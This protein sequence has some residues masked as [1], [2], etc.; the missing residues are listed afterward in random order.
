MCDAKFIVITAAKDE[1]KYIGKTIES[2]ISQTVRPRQWIVVDDGSRDETAGIALRSRGG[3]PW[4]KVIS[5][6][7]KGYRDVGAGQAEA[8]HHG[9]QQLGA[10]NYGFLFNIDADIVLQPDYFRVILSKFAKNHRLGIAGG[11]LYESCNGKLTKMR[12]LP[13][14]MIGAIQCWRKRC[15][16]EIGGLARGPGWDGIA[17][18]KAMMLGWQTRTFEDEVLKTIHLRPEGSSIKNRYQGWAQ[19]W[20]SPAFCRSTS[21]LALASAL[22]HAVDPPY[23]LSGLCMVMGYLTALLNG[24]EQYSDQE[25]KRYVRKWQLHKLANLVRLG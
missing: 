2:V 16:Q 5:R 7:D 21:C 14:G 25:F 9:V 24:S 18:F 6:N 15:F 11:Q 17:C 20:A 8:I 4:I 3:H 23:V 12:V 13:L 1:A 19:A 10:D 22:Y